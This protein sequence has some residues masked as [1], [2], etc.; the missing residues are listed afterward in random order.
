MTT[1]RGIRPTRRQ[2][3]SAGTRDQVVAAA[4]RL[5][6]ANGYGATS[7]TALAAEAGVAVQTVYNSV[8]SN[9]ALLSAVLDSL[10]SGPDSPVP[11]PALMRERTAAAADA[12]E[13]V[14]I[15]ADW[16]LEANQRLARLW[17]VI[18]EAAPLYEEVADLKRRRDQARLH[19]YEGAAAEL[20]RRG[21]LAPGVTDAEVAATI[22]SLGHPVVYRSLVQ[23]ADWTD[24]QYRDWILGSLRR[25]LLVPR[26]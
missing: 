15:L 7:V 21:A 18:S 13:V 5:F 11:V 12:D 24:E 8:G 4:R 3:Q 20:R 23:D 17:E 2:A 1:A 14:R 19:N 16:L 26:G 6:L 25:G 9:G 22:W 10:V